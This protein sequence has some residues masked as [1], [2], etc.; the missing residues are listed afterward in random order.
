LEEE[1]VDGIALRASFTRTRLAVGRVGRV[2]RARLAG[3]RERVGVGGLWTHGKTPVYM[4]VVVRFA[5]GAL[6]FQASK[7][8]RAQVVTRDAFGEVGV[9]VMV[10][11]TLFHLFD[12]FAAVI[13]EPERLAGRTS[14]AVF[15]ERSSWAGQV[16]TDDRRVVRIVV[17]IVPEGTLETGI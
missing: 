13:D 8:V 1:I 2:A 10:F 12:T 4:Q 16:T 7:A 3:R 11:G 14:L 6:V 9:H 5:L 17:D 15:E